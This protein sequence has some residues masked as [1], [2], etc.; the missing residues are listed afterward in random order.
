MPR[1]IIEFDKS[2]AQDDFQYMAV[3]VETGKYEIG[4]IVIDKPW[5]S[6]KRDW[7]YYIFKN[8]Y[9]EGGFCGGAIDLGLS[10]VMVNPDTIE[11]FTQTA[12]I[13]YNQSIGFDSVLVKDFLGDA[14]GDNVVAFIGTE[15][16][17]PFELW[18]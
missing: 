1:E 5:Y 7:T 4:Y 14:N 8:K 9:G 18:R 3:S 12:K 2:N 10:K 13:K 17:I 16:S 6:N 11:P 15:D